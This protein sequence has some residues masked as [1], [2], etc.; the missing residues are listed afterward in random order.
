[1]EGRG[2]HAH[3]CTREKRQEEHG[4]GDGYEPS[5]HRNFL[6]CNA[7]N[8]DAPDDSSGAQAFHQ[9]FAH[10]VHSNNWT[11]VII[12]RANRNPKSQIPTWAAL[13]LRQLYTPRCTA[14]TTRPAT[15]TCN[16][17]NTTTTWSIQWTCHTSHVTCHMLHVTCH[18]HQPQP[19]AIELPRSVLRCCN[20]IQLILLQRQRGVEQLKTC[21]LVEGG[22]GVRGLGVS[23]QGRCD[24]EVRDDDGPEADE[25]PS[26]CR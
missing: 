17:S 7:I 20:R 2:A 22:A 3:D 9:P 8:A 6:H 24:D 5:E 11:S 12:T 16:M 19:H 21:K 15:T 14:P 18:T 25:F 13:Q 1:M 4:D 10:V 23:L 26:N